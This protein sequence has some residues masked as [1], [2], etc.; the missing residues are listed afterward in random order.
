MEK[1]LRA[2]LEELAL[3][4]ELSIRHIELEDIKPVVKP[5]NL[6]SGLRQQ[7]PFMRRIVTRWKNLGHEHQHPAPDKSRWKIKRPHA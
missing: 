7:K 5:L 6:E 4:D 1:E 3:P 2:I